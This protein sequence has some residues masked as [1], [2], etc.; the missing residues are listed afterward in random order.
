MLVKHT[1]IACLDTIIEKYGK[2]DTEGILAAIHIV[3]GS[4]GI[5]HSD[6]RIQIISLLCLTSAVEILGPDTVPLIPGA[7]SVAL[8][9]L[10]ASV[11]EDEKV[12]GL[13]NAVY[14][15]LDALCVHLPWIMTTDYY[16]RILRLSH[17]S[18]E[19]GLD[20]SANENRL[21][22]L[23]TIVRQVAAKDYFAAIKRTMADA[24]ATGPLVRAGSNGTLLHL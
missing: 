5:G 2:K 12:V 13:H 16:D 23:R 8:N 17:K 14:S 1:A 19:A 9:H 15:F 4:H 22:V 10:E 6:R 11:V 20:D 24:I 21:H 18:A 7:L 3:A